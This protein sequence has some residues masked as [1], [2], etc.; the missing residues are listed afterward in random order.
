MSDKL[1]STDDFL[2]LLDRQRVP[3]VQIMQ[4]LLHDHVAATGKHGVLLAD[5]GGIDRGLIH[6]VLRAVDEADQ[7]A[8]IKVGETMHFVRCGDGIA[9]PRHDLCRQLEAQ[10]GARGADMKEDVARRCDGMMPAADFAEGMQVFRLWL[11]EETVPYVG[12]ERHDAG[13]PTLKVTEADRA[14]QR[15]QVTT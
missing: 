4:V 10:I 2:L 9:K 3:F 5:D 6:G 11:S 8:I 15:G 14:Q 7:V 1:G 13:Q 12:A